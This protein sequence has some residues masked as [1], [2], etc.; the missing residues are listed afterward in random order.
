MNLRVLETF[1]AIHDGESFIDAARRLGLTQSAVSMQIKSLEEELGVELFDRRVRP[2]V[3]TPAAMAIVTPARE[4][5]TLVQSIAERV[6]H[7]QS[8]SGRL[9]LGAIQTASVSLLPDCLSLVSRR[10]PGIQVTVETGLSAL[11]LNASRLGF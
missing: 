7:S 6:K 3:M 2:P 11:L 10:Y 1:I 8:L 4:V 5:L 9:A